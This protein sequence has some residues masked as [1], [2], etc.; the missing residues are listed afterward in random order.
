M[1]RN[2]ASTDPPPL[3]PPE[4]LPGTRIVLRRS[5]LVDAEDIFRNYATDETVT[6]FLPWNPHADVNATRLFLQRANEQWRNGTDFSYSIIHNDSEQVIGMISM[7]PH[8][9]I[10]EMGYVLSRHF[11]GQGIMTEALTTLS[12]WCL[13]QPEIW[14]VEAYC[15]VENKASAR[16]MVKAGMQ[17]EGVLARYLLKPGLDARPRNAYLYARTKDRIRA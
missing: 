17:E 8:G 16:V 5:S 12:D 13:G 2:S 11:W 10:V 1:S 14:R 9:H 3:T 6:H 4:R 7:R 15:D